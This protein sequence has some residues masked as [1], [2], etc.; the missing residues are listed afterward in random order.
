M[1]RKMNVLLWVFLILLPM[2]FLRAQT[3][4]VGRVV[5]A[6]GIVEVLRGGKLPA[7]PLKKGDP[8]YEKDVIRTKSNSKAEIA[9]KDGDVIRIAQKSRVD[10]SEYAEDQGKRVQLG[11]RRGTVRAVV[12]EE[13][14]RRVVVDPKANKFEIKTPVAVAGVR[15]TDFFVSHR[16]VATT[17]VVEK[18]LVAVYNPKIPEVVV[19]IEAGKKVVVMENK[20]PTPPLTV[21]EN[22]RKRLETDTTVGE[23]VSVEP[24]EEVGAPQ[25][26]LETTPIASPPAPPT[27]EAGVSAPQETTPPLTEVVQEDLMEET[28]EE[29]TPTEPTNFFRTNVGVLKDF[30]FVKF[31]GTTMNVLGDPAEGGGIITQMAGTLEGTGDLFSGS[32]VPITIVGQHNPSHRTDA[33]FFLLPFVSDANPSDVGNLMGLLP[34]AEG[35]LSGVI[36]K[37]FIGAFAFAPY[38]HGV[39]LYVKNGQAGLF[40]I[41]ATSGSFDDGTGQWNMNGEIKA[42]SMGSTSASSLSDIQEISGSGRVAGE[43][44]AELSIKFFKL[45]DQSWGIFYAGGQGTAGTSGAGFRIAFS[46]GDTDPEYWYSGRT[47]NLILSSTHKGLVGYY[48]WSEISFFSNESQNLM[49]GYTITEPLSFGS[50]VGVLPIGGLLSYSGNFT[51]STP[52]NMVGYM[53]GT[54][55][56]WAEG[57][58]SFD[59]LGKFSPGDGEIFNLYTIS[60]HPNGSDPTQNIG[61]QTLRRTG[62]LESVGYWGSMAGVSYPY[63]NYEFKATGYALFAKSNGELGIMR[64]KDIVGEFDFGTGFW[65]GEGSIG[66]FRLGNTTDFNITDPDAWQKLHNQTGGLISL[67]DLGAGSHPFSLLDDNGFDIT[68]ITGDSN[69]IFTKVGNAPIGLWTNNVAFDQYSAN[70][71]DAT[72]FFGDY[73][74]SN[75]DPTFLISTYTTGSLTPTSSGYHLE[76]KAPTYGYF[77]RI[78]GSESMTGILIGETIGQFDVTD[79]MSSWLVQTGFWLETAKFM[80]MVC[81]GGTCSTTSTGLT[82]TQQALKDLGVPVVEVGRTSFTGASGPITSFNIDNMVFFANNQGEKALIWASSSVSGTYTTDPTTPHL[83]TLSG[84]A[85]ELYVVIKNWQSGAWMAEIGGSGINLGPSPNDNLK[86]DGVGAGTYG[87]GSFSGTAAGIVK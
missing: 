77:G 23:G 54:D 32:S 41:D 34:S 35:Q 82:S 6:E 69:F 66:M 67:E 33:K 15:G 9:L 52:S 60:H 14:T 44:E 70:I 79:S 27:T 73:Y 13:T 8:I 4:E 17:V 16:G 40:I 21:P 58:K 12:S 49:I 36:F 19:P 20:P 71:S 10:I 76:L 25:F 55:N 38:G 31:S 57:F 39:G 7:Q 78:D 61:N 11:L 64:M 86:I 62:D 5:Q 80:D 85:G 48:G 72:Q 59:M 26:A 37:G 87:S 3:R 50:A 28:Q 53:G 42:I 45:P 24:A 29:I 47:K 65:Y 22:E 30:G 1:L 46:V 56:L 83:I 75:T 74:D 18:G 2:S 43:A 51:S 81:P 63:E 68:G 84:P